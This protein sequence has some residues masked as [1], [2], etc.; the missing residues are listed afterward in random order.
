L[1][2][3]TD[4]QWRAMAHAAHF[5]VQELAKLCGL[6]L[7]TLERS[8]KRKWNR[9][10]QQWLHELRMMEARRLL[11]EGFSITENADSIGGNLLVGHEWCR[12]NLSISSHSLLFR[13]PGHWRDAC[14]TQSTVNEAK[15]IAS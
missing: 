15:T 2:R 11:L 6:P 10:P 7:R 12:E 13:P 14:V 3:V 9:C 4:Q 1:T 5:N 8:L